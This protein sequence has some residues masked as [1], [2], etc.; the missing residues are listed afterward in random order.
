MHL[1][2]LLSSLLAWSEQVCILV[3]AGALASIAISS[4]KARLAMWQA[5]LLLSLF[6]PVLEP[7]KTPPL[8]LAAPAPAS[9]VTA[10]TVTPATQQPGL[11]WRS[12]YWFWIIAIGA[13]L[14][15]IFAA[16]GLLRL[17]R[18]RLSA[19]P[20]PEPPL[21]FASNIASWYS[22]DSAGGPVTYG[23]RRPV[24]LLPS[25]ALDLPADLLEAIQCH[26]LIH[27]YRGDWLFVLAENLLRSLLWFHPA[28]WFALSRIN[29][30]RE[31]VVDREAVA[32]LQNRESYLD[33][34][35][36]VAAY[37]LR[38]NCAPAFLRK[39]QLLARVEAVVKEVSM[40]RSRI[41]AAIAAVCFILP[42]AIGAG[43][44]LFPFTAPL[45]VQ[46]QTAPDSP[47]ITV[48]PGAALLH[49]A[50]VRTPQGSTASGKVILE[51]TLDAQ[52]DVSDAR[53][54]SGPQ[55]LRSA[56]LSSVLQW[57]YQPGPSVAEVSIQFAGTIRTPAA[58]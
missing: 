36:A 40:S 58:A 41:A 52:G 29:L 57:H 3:A 23:W 11:H 24:I 6:L 9:V 53:V 51:A 5:L 37:R 17:R 46:A 22:T 34:L 38:P 28:V 33:A 32:L 2:T 44:W 56:A 26:E 18:Y 30:A 47:G 16:A 14:R 54:I 8:L 20:L 43:I 48:E 25:E 13:A 45:K 4:P 12:E 10:F 15:L 31:Q 35:V 19:R 27:V 49:R 55:E 39:R 7:W 1:L 21:R 42:L 50:P